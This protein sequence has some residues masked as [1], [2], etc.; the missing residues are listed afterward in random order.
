MTEFEKSDENPDNA[1]RQQIIARLRKLTRRESLKFLYLFDEYCPGINKDFVQENLIKIITQA[2]VGDRWVANE[3][4][5]IGLYLDSATFYTLIFHEAAHKI[6]DCIAGTKKRTI[7]F[8]WEEKFCYKVSKAVC[9]ALNL[10]YN[11]KIEQVALEFNRLILRGE[12]TGRYDRLCQC[13]EA[14]VLGFYATSSRATSSF[15]R[16]STCQV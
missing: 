14:D 2:E 5:I 6:L 15:L 9:N 4:V 10:P 16:D 11:K 7:D 13:P 8:E 12:L 3:N 1:L